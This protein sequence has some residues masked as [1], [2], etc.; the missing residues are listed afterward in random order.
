MGLVCHTVSCIGV[1]L[2]AV[3]HKCTVIIKYYQ[4]L[5]NRICINIFIVLKILA[6]EYINI[7]KYIKMVKGKI[8]KNVCNP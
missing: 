8:S 6:Q 2:F 4:H 5:W 7:K 3:L 1:I